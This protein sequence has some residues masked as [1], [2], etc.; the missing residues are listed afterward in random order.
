MSTVS[1]PGIGNDRQNS[2]QT[3]SAL[4][5]SQRESATLDIQ[6]Q[7]AQSDVNAVVIADTESSKV[8]LAKTAFPVVVVDVDSFSLSSAGLLLTDL[9]RL[10]P[11]AE[12]IVVLDEPNFEAA[13]QLIRRGANDIMCRK[14]DNLML[15]G[16]RVAAALRDAKQRADRSQML[17]D[18]SLLTED[19]L[20]RLTET[21]RRI[22]EMKA[23]LNTNNRGSGAPSSPGDDYV[24]VL[25]VEEDGW[26]SQ[27]LSPLLSASFSL[28]TVVSGG[29]ALD[30]ASERTFDLALIKETLPDLPSKT[31]I[32]SLQAQSP[33]T[34]VL[35]YS[36]PSRGKPG[37]I[38]RLEP[39]G[40][41]TSPLLSTFTSAKQLAERLVELQQA[42]VARR[43]ERRYLAEFRAE[44]YE[45]LK[46]LADLRKR[47]READSSQGRGK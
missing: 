33:E 20:Y 44:N 13:V 41:K 25:V 15:L 21:A 27:G 30:R 26:L 18:Y 31:V 42:Q 32:R 37:H 8:A 23:Q 38:D 1:K 47:Y 6:T 14:T 3:E 22:G 29:A 9:R 36:P 40:G 45:L 46:R 4:L 7:F 2:S 39:G 16:A 11:K 34:L 35:L 10:A 24:H 12:L 28:T 17:R 5:V 19:L 43:R